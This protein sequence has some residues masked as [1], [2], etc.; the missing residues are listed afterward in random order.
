MI[1]DRTRNEIEVLVQRELIRA[2]EDLEKQIKETRRGHEKELH[3]MLRGS[4]KK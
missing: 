1:D 3:R 2:L 4:D